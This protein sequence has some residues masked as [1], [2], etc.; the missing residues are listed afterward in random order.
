MQTAAMTSRW[1]Q[2]TTVLWLKA[3]KTGAFFFFFPYFGFIFFSTVAQK[4]NKNK[5]FFLKKKTKLELS[6]GSRDF[7]PVFH[8]TP[9]QIK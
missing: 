6:R 8:K 7:M 1:Q 9:R 4:A 3:F 2:R 5:V